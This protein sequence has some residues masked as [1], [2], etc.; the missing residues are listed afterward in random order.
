MVAVRL[1]LTAEQG[2][3]L[4][5]AADVLDADGITPRNLAGWTGQSQIR[6]TAEA[7]TVLATATVTVDAANGIVT[8]TIDDA[9]TATFTW[10]SAKYDLII[11]DGTDT[12]ALLYGDVRVRPSITR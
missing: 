2:R 11:T 6:A 9:D 7:T 5:Y 3:T 12:E 8:A 4:R 1:D 10:R